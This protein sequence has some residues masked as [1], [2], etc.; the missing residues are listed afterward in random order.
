MKPYEYY[1]MLFI[2]LGFFGVIINK[3]YN[4]YPRD[5]RNLSSSMYDRL[6][7]RRQVIQISWR[8]TVSATRSEW[9]ST[10]EVEEQTDAMVKL[11][12]ILKIIFC[13]ALINREQFLFIVSCV[14]MWIL[15]LHSTIWIVIVLWS[16]DTL[17]VSLV[18]CFCCWCFWK[19][20]LTNWPIFVSWTNHI[21]H[22][23]FV[24]VG[25]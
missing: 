22:I 2:L 14:E 5:A 10:E 6:A 13:A 16:V 18:I 21:E 24:V 8:E 4:L 25:K 1:F 11:N 19:K 12:L 7:Y 17:I 3:R 23:C 9:G 15:V 20:K